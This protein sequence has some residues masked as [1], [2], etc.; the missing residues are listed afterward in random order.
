MRCCWG[1]CLAARQSSPL[2][3]T[4]SL[5]AMSAASGSARRA[6]RTRA[7]GRRATSAPR[8]AALPA[9]ARSLPGTLSCLARAAIRP[10]AKGAIMAIGI[11]AFMRAHAAQGRVRMG[12]QMTGNNAATASS[13]VARSAAFLR[14]LQSALIGDACTSYAST[15]S[16]RTDL[17]P[18]ALNALSALRSLPAA[19]LATTVEFATSSPALCARS[20]VVS[21]GSALAPTAW[22]M[23]AAATVMLLLPV[24]PLLLLSLAVPPLLLPLPQLLPPV[25][26]AQRHLN[27]PA[28]APAS[29]PAASLESR[30]HT[31]AL[32]VS[33]S[34][35]VSASVYVQ[36]CSWP[37]FL[38]LL[39]CKL[40]TAFNVTYGSCR[41]RH[42]TAT[43]RPQGNGRGVKANMHAYRI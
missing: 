6:T 27:L 14:I 41:A 35:F 43:G 18:T 10:F 7:L 33:V 22:P 3:L 4:A 21:V 9:A 31:S 2:A 36:V 32:P 24:L 34:V 1:C 42:C 13:G 11:G 19:T 40:Y 8:T 12:A 30:V 5:S 38:C 39:Q 28:S 23:S 29:V 26:P 17:K 16:V 37:R 15:S 20:A 25:L